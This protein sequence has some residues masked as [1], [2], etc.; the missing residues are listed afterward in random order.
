[1]DAGF[2]VLRFWNNDVHGNIEGVLETIVGALDEDTPL[3]RIADA[4]RPPRKGE[5]EDA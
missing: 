1:M 2:R 4:I 5:V 3:T